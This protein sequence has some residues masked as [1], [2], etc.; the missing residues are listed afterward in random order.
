MATSRRN[1]RSD[2]PSRISA[3]A[4]AIC[5]GV[6]YG[7]AYARGVTE[8]GYCL[9][10]DFYD[11]NLVKAVGGVTADALISVSRRVANR[12][13]LRRWRYVSGTRDV[14]GD[15]LLEIEA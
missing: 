3:S 4:I 1:C 5:S 8:C 15:I 7:S 10:W 2:S 9:L 6:Q 13:R 14:S 11:G 12:G